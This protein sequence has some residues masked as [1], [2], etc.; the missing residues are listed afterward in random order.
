MPCYMTRDQQ[1]LT[2]AFINNAKCKHAPNLSGVSTTGALPAVLHGHLVRGL[3]SPADQTNV[4]GGG[5]ANDLCVD[6]S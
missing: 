6:V 2:T 4:D 5:G 1:Q 3:K